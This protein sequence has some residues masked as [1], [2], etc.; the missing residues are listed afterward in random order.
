MKI[1]VIVPAFNEEKLIA[2]CVSSIR[3]ALAAN[4]REG[5]EWELIVVDNRSTD[6]TAERAR[7]AGARVVEEPKRQIARAR[8]RGAQAAGG[9]WLVFVDADS[10]VSARLMAGVLDR[11]RSGA[12]A[13]GGAVVAMP[14]APLW[15]GFW[16]GVWNLISCTLRWAAGAFLWCRADAFKEVGGFNEDLYAS[17]EIDLSRRLKRWAKARGLAFSILSRRPLLTSDRKIRLYSRRELAKYMLRF[18][19]RP[20]KTVRSREQL[21]LWYDGR[22]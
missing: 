18:L 6:A 11:M 22:R 1:S 21:D 16:I 15:L 9:D 20:L 10:T 14:G 2:G 5:L 13:G 12:H 19:L 3:A 7:A 4:A 8:N 17:E